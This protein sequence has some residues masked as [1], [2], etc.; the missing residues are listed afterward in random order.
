[1]GGRP[2]EAMTELKRKFM[3]C[4]ILLLVLGAVSSGADKEL[5][6]KQAEEL[7]LNIPDSV[8][9]RTKGGCPK[10]VVN[11]TN[12][13]QSTIFFSVHNPCDKSGAASNKIGQ[14]TVSL[15]NG[16]VW[17]DVDRRDDGKNLID[18]ARMRELRRKFFSKK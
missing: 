7:V 18:S 10:A 5:T 11:W 12:D 2:F 16:E 9:S 8:A 17:L 13:K 3:P 15:K 14:F 6:P 1:M 4:I